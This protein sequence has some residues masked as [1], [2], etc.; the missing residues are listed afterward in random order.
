[1][2]A[3][4]ATRDPIDVAVGARIRLRRKQLGMSQ[5]RLAEALGV[6]FQQVQK[7]EV[8]AN[9]LS[10]ATLVRAAGCMETT[11]A[12]LMGETPGQSTETGLLHLLNVDGATELLQAFAAIPSGRIRR[13]LLSLAS[14]LG[15]A[16]LRADV[17]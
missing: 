11:V 8:G 1:M 15:E 4:L 2:V 13:S 10:S 12:E 17:A 5:A 6:T 14:E 9:R 3:D 7:Y 16:R